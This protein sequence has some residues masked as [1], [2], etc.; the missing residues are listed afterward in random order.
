ML[1]RDLGDG[2]DVRDIVPGVAYALDIHQFRLVVDLLLE[3]YGVV[4]LH[5]AS[6]DAEPGEEDFELVVGA[7]VEVRGRDDVV[8]GVGEGGDGHK[9]GGLARGSG[10]GGDTAFEGGYTFFEDVNCGLGD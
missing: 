10:N 8:A 6:G 7:T 9:L 1:V 4:A 3:V 2:F 5:E